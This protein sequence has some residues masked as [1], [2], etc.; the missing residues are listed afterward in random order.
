MLSWEENDHSAHIRE[1]KAHLS[2]SYNWH[3]YQREFW[4]IK[5]D[6]F[7]RCVLDA[8][9]RL[10]AAILKL[11][12]LGIVCGSPD[13][14]NANW[15]WGISTDG[16]TRL[17][18]DTHKTVFR[19]HLQDLVDMTEIMTDDVYFITLEEGDVCNIWDVTGTQPRGSL[20]CNNACDQLH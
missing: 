1:T 14:Q 10:Q 5:K 7:G 16:I 17:P 8:R 2:F 18:D 6:L 4:D 13:K 19:F 11:D 3:V 20:N 15:H 9:R 12:A